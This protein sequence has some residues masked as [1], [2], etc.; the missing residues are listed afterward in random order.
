MKN[1]TI[2]MIFAGY[3]AFVAYI[4]SVTNALRG[5]PDGALTYIHAIGS[6]VLSLL[7]AL[8]IWAECPKKE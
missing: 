2:V 5:I 1:S 8:F 6:L 3:M 7:S 4:L